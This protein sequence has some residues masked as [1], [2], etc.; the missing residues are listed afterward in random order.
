MNKHSL[1][2]S[3][4]LLIAAAISFLFLAI[5]VRVIHPDAKELDFVITATGN[6]EYSSI[7]AEY[8]TE[9]IVEITSYYKEGERYHIIF[10]GISP[11]ETSAKIFA[12]HSENPEV[13]DSSFIDIVHTKTGILFTDKTFIFNGYQ[14]LF[15]SVTLVFIAFSIL[16]LVHFIQTKI[17]HYFSYESILSLGLFMYFA[18]QSCALLPFAIESLI[19]PWEHYGVIVFLCTNYVLSIVALI[20]TPVLLIFSLFISS[21]NIR[22]IQKEGKKPSNL[23]GILIS[24]MLFGGLLLIFIIMKN[25]TMSLEFTP[26]DT[27]NILTRNIIAS[28]FVYFECNLLATFILCRI[29]GRHKPKLDK[30][31]IIILGCG[32]KDDGTLYPLLQGRADAAIAFYKKQLEKTGKAARFVPSGGQGPDECI[33][34]GEA[35]KNYLIKQ[36]IPADRILPETRSENTYQNMKYSKEIIDKDNPDSK[37]IFSTTNYHVYRSGILASMVGMNADGLGSKTKWYFWPNA[38]IRE[39]IGMVVNGRRIHIF[40]IV[41]LVVQTIILGNLQWLL[42]AIL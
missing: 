10:D 11:G 21:S 18:L 6:Y 9:D 34:E 29:A 12:V 30:D 20:S 33:P 5:V 19:D 40:L 14:Y 23:L 17:R 35:I 26:G 28:L 41:L 38:L 42:Q 36:G 8:G 27:A 39:F 25:S 1:S 4:K 15:I 37:M 2:L 13:I 24:L 16:T 7:T 22:L 32:I 3:K 31:H